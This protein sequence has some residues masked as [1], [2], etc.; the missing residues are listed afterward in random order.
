MIRERGDP[1][2]HF[3]LNCMVRSCPRLP[4]LPFR[5]ETLDA[6]LDGAAEEFLNDTRHVKLSPEERT[7]YLSSILD[8]YERT[9]STSRPR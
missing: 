6:Q 7:V 9:S 1:R 4:Q 5:A 8:W 2:I 3:A